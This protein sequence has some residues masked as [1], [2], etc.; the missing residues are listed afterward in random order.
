MTGGQIIFEMIKLVLQF[1]GALFIAWR[2]V[3][4]ALGRYK[5]EKLW[6]RRLAAY[7]DLL[8][9]LA[10]MDQVL[11]V[12]ELQAMNVPTNL[13]DAEEEEIRTRYREARRNL[14]E[15]WGIAQLL[16]PED[17]AK[18]LASISTD[19]D[20]A[21]HKADDWM[22]AIGEEWAILQKARAKILEAGKRD[23]QSFASPPLFRNAIKSSS[24]A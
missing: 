5:S 12:W 6:E 21:R 7:S 16:L 1:A 24:K 3:Q 8:A 10:Q 15:A 2:A 20:N 13:S 22:T 4:W 9:S 19:I 17:I 11:G 23:L 14:E 18:L